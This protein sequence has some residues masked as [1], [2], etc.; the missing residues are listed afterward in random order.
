VAKNVREIAVTEPEAMRP[1]QLAKVDDLI[2][3]AKAFEDQS[4]AI[5]LQVGYKLPGDSVSPDLICRDIAANQQRAAASCLEIGR[6]LVVLKSACAHGE[7]MKRLDD[8]GIDDAVARKFAQSAI[9]FSNRSTS[10]DLVG[11]IRNQSQLF[12]LLVLDDEQIDEL[13]ETGQIGGVKRDELFAMSI[14]DL[15]AAVRKLRND[16]ATKNRVIGNKE[17]R[18]T[19]LEEQLNYKPAEDDPA[20]RDEYDIAEAKRTKAIKDLDD[21][22]GNIR[23]SV[24]GLQPYFMALREAGIPEVEWWELQRAALGRLIVAVRAIATDFDVPLHG[25][26]AVDDTSDAEYAGQLADKVV[27]GDAPAQDDAEWETLPGEGADDG[28]GE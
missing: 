9:K 5:A 15:R 22:V 7:Y 24:H 21:E 8:L 17:S 10:S 27:F 11:A 18:I 3:Q 12:E 19:L 28:A 26:G 6:G 23:L 4:R 13:A 14:K 1:E 25:P 20:P 16:V 2:T